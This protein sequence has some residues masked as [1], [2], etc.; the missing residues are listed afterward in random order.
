MTRRPHPRQWLP[1]AFVAL[2]A[3]PAP[4][5]MA[6]IVAAALLATA[7]RLGRLGRRL[8]VRGARSGAAR[9]DASLLGVD[10]R[11]RT[12]V[13]SDRELSAHGLILG[14]SGAG[15]STTLL[16]IL[17]EQI[18]R[19]RPVVA[20]DLKGSPAF[21]QVLA[22]AAAAAGR[23]FQRWSIDGGAHWN[24][25]QHGNPTEL[26]D[27]LISTERFTE[28]H[29]MRAA[30]RHVQI[31]LN[32]LARAHPER[33]PVLP[34]VVK[35]MDPHRL[36]SLLRGVDRGL[37]EDVQ[38]Y[39]ARMTPDQLSAVRGLQTRLA[40][41]TESHTAPY[42][43]PAPPGSG[44]ATIDLRAALRGPEVVLFSLNSSRYGRLA[45]QLGTLVVQDLTSASG[46]RVEQP[47]GETA[48]IGIDEFSALGA[49][50]V[51]ALL[52]RGRESGLCVLVATQELADLA[53]AARGLEDQVVG[54]TAVKIVHRQEVPGSAQAIALMAGTERVWEHTRQT[55]SQLLFGYD[56]GRGTKQQVE[57]FIVDPNEIK[58]LRTGEAVVISNC[59]AD[60]PGRFA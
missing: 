43:T 21:A 50:H 16:R 34:E 8:S 12:V 18:A 56:T 11:G 48:L 55:A 35:L 2:L 20:L 36:P 22:D 10:Q 38:D 25:L 58:S 29:Y 40:V 41:L 49:D 14:A 23:P 9:G 15:K 59:A 19:G 46:D 45:A 42:L 52:S 44:M 47:P 32:V 39:L 6:L 3:A 53:R 57:R 30:E 5:G 27:K 37:R 60:G 1:L 28:P 24:P 4:W 33:A 13:L 31:V 51:I 54:V 17:T 7:Y 26:K